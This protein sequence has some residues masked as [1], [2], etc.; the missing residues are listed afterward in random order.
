MEV[1]AGCHGCVRGHGGVAGCL[2]GGGGGELTSVLGR[3]WWWFGRIGY[4]DVGFG[5]LRMKT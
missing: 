4:G 2:G 3:C 5:E 1:G